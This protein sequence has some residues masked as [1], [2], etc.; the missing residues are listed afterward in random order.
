MKKIVN[1]LILA[2]LSI[3]FFV[4]CS[5]VTPSQTQNT[6]NLLNSVVPVSV[7]Y[8]VAKEPKTIPYFIASSDVIAVIAAGTN[9]NP[10][11]LISDLSKI[12]QTSTP[13]AKLAVMTG[14]G[15]YTSFFSTTVANDTNTTLILN[16]LSGDIKLGLGTTAAKKIKRH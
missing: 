15:I 16:T 4:G 5:T 6:V 10:A 8:A 2:L 3:P 13:E 12:P 14:V 1:S 9:Y 7:A 11:V